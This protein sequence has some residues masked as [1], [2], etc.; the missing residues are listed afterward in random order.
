MVSFA[1][2]LRTCRKIAFARYFVATHESKAAFESK[3]ANNDPCGHCDNVRLVFS[4]LSPVL[5]RYTV[6]EGRR[7]DR[8]D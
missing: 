4:S 3:G 1:E 5:M 2:D 8:I 6:Y 7:D